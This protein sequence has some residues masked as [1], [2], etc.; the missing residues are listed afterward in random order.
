MAGGL[1]ANRAT[2]SARGGTTGRAAGCPA[3]FGFAGGRSGFPPPTG[4]PA[5]ADGAADAGPGR[6]DGRGG[7]GMAGTVPAVTKPGR[8]TPG[9]IVGAATPGE[10]LAAGASFR[11]SATSGGS[12]CLGPDKIC[13]GLG[14]GGAVRGW[15]M[16]PRLSGILGS[17]GG[18]CGGTGTVCA[19]ACPRG[20]VSGCP[21]ARGGRK[22]NVG[23][24]GAAGGS[25]GAGSLATVSATGAAPLFSGIAGS[26]A[27]TGAAGDISRG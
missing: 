9:T 3:R 22:G 21:V 18:A 13:P 26:A 16:G 27:V 8:G 24:I 5:G 23:L 10:A 15:I 6:S 25:A 17:D 20:G 14:A 1:A 11:A 19:V 2:I 12:G 4:A 7:A